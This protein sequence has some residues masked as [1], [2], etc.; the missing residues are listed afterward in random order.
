[1]KLLT[2]KQKEKIAKDYP[3]YSQESKGKKAV[4]VAKFFLGNWT[5][6]ITEGSFDGDDFLMFGL[7]IN[8]MGD[9]FGY[10]SFNELQSL[11]VNVKTPFGLLPL[12]VERD[13]YFTPTLLDEINEPYLKK[14][15][16]N[17]YAKKEEVANDNG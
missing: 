5:W 3:L 8:G 6:Y 12:E 16:T 2:Q 7:V 4:V 13:L 10:V 15:I 1:M 9:E 17:F 11:K 14:F